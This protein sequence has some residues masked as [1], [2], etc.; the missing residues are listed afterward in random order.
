MKIFICKCNNSTREQCISNGLFGSREDWI[1]R[2]MSIDD[3][4]V[5][6]DFSPNQQF[7][8][9]I[10]QVEEVGV[11][12]DVKAFDGKFKHQISV[13]QLLNQPKKMTKD[14]FERI[15][16]E[17][18]SV[19]SPIYVDIGLDFKN[20][21]SAFEI[22]PETFEKEV[23][24]LGGI[25][26]DGLFFYSQTEIKIYEVLQNKNVLFFTNASAMLGGKNKKLRPDFLICSEG[27]WGILE[28]MGKPWH[29]KTTAMEDHERARLFKDYKIDCIEFYDATYC[30]HDPEKIVNDF[31]SR[32]KS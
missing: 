19:K 9:G 18:I 30:Y 15:S 10:W 8:Y 6:Y 21:V 29:P 12:L 28:V 22:S 1:T 31:L 20:F 4:C 16:N 23:K 25:P 27:R 2:E 14:Q 3:Y 17:T 24:K 13:K 7:I 32:L 5:L 11:D 26:Y